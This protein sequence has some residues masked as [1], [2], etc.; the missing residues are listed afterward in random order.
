MVGTATDNGVKYDPTSHSLKIIK[1]Y[2]SKEELIILKHPTKSFVKFRY[3]IQ[4]RLFEETSRPISKRLEAVERTNDY[5]QRHL[6]T[7]Q[8]ENT[9][10]NYKINNDS[11]LIIVDKKEDQEIESIVTPKKELK[12]DYKSHIIEK[13]PIHEL[14]RNSESF[15]EKQTRILGGG[16]LSSS[17]NSNIVQNF[18]ILDSEKIEGIRNSKTA[19]SYETFCDAF[20]VV[21]LSTEKSEIIP[22]SDK[23]TAPCKHKNCGIFYSYKPEIVSKYPESSEALDLSSNVIY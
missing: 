20:F 18:H 3:L 11:S 15:C 7:I 1:G 19:K 2:H 13:S 5:D 17:N 6:S 22:G 21:S 8:E 12:K 4:E 16:S 23:F 14:K 9:S 10:S